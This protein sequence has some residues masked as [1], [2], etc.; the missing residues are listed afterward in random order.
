MPNRDAGEFGGREHAALDVDVGVD[1]TGQENAGCDGSVGVER[2]DRVD[3]SV[4]DFD[5][6]GKDPTGMEIDDPMSQ[7]LHVASLAERLGRPPAK[8]GRIDFM[9]MVVASDIICMDRAA[10]LPDIVRIDRN[11]LRASI[12]CDRNAVPGVP[13]TSPDARRPCSSASSRW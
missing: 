4:E 12:S 3:P 10:I 6:G 2:T 9:E 13:T 5:F 1:E 11:D 7:G 8:P